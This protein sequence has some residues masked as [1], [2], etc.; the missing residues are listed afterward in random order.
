MASFLKWS[1][2]ILMATIF[3]FALIAFAIN[4]AIDNN[5]AITLADDDSTSDLYS[6]AS[7]NLSEFYSQT[8]VSTEA[9]GE[10]TTD[11]T[12]GTSEGGGQFKATPGV[13]I[14]QVKVIL[15]NSWTAI[16]GSGNQFTIILYSIL[17]II[18]LIGFALA[19]KAWFGRNP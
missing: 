11:V 2:S 15:S 7:D 14:S 6:A 3:A 5:T 19:Y 13:S 8:E 4:F 16:F 12:T 9:F 1:S 10:S 18:G 17:G